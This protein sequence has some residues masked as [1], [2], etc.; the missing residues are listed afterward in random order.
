MG[1]YDREYSREPEQG[2]H[3]SAPTTATMQLLIVTIGVYLGQIL[4]QGL[5][6]WIALPADWWRRPWEAYRLVTYGFAHSPS[7]IKHV[8]FNMLGLWFFGG[9]IEQRYGRRSFLIFYLASIVFAGLVWS[10]I[11]TAAGARSWCLGASGAITAILVVFALLYPHMQVM[12][13]F[14]F[15]MPAWVLAVIVVASD[16][17]GALN[18]TGNTA[19]T[20][21][22]AGALF[23]LYYQRMGSH[24]AARLAD[25][26]SGVSLKRRP[27]LRVHEPDEDEADELSAR[28]DAILEK[29]QREGQDSLTW[30]ERRILQKASRKAQEKRR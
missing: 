1:L 19:F 6:E 25:R 23:G 7:D 18:R 26:L 8:I 4:F 15:P 28:V 29:I 22:L 27:K 13:M 24:Q 14:L 3:V 30:N 11:D 2:F 21:H 12:M 20:A 10:G 16:M 17:I 5:T 9:F